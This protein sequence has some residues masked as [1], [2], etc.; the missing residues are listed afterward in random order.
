MCLLCLTSLLIFSRFVVIT[1]L[2]QCGI[3]HYTAVKE[4]ICM[5]LVRSFRRVAHSSLYYLYE[6]ISSKHILWL[7]VPPHYHDLYLVRGH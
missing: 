6:S 3:S 4:K 7:K 1:G 5:L 2:L